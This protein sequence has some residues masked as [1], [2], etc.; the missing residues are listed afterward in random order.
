MQRESRGHNFN[1]F[2]DYCPVSGDPSQCAVA[3]IMYISYSLLYRSLYIKYSSLKLHLSA[4]SEAQYNNDVIR[5][6]Y[7]IRLRLSC[8]R[9]HHIDLKKKKKYIYI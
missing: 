2:M 3:Y 7:G 9:S 5:N 6:N 1:V 8:L 4:Q